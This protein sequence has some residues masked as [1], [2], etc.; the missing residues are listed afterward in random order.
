MTITA[1]AAFAHDVYNAS[2]KDGKAS[3]EKEVKVARITSVVI[4]VL[5][6]LGA[7]WW[8]RRLPTRAEFGLIRGL[9]PRVLKLR[10]WPPVVNQTPTVMLGIF[11]DPRAAG[12]FAFSARLVEIVIKVAV[13]VIQGVAQS[14]I[15]ELRRQILMRNPC[16]FKNIMEQPGHE[17]GR[18]QAELGQI[19]RHRQAVR[20]VGVARETHLTLVRLVGKTVGAPDQL[21][22]GFRIVFPDVLQQFGEFVTHAASSAETRAR[23]MRAYTHQT[24]IVPFCHNAF[25]VRDDG[26]DA[27]ISRQTRWIRGLSLIHISEPTRLLSISYAVFCLK[28]KTAAHIANASKQDEQLK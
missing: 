16:V 13:R 8:P 19:G 27:P 23:R 15:A 12:L 3:P 21:R 6:I 20:D 10:T 4:G 25:M 2:S 28:K 14:A 1:S 17:G 9:G 18:V 24:Y 11:A 22:V 7:R 26:D 5:A